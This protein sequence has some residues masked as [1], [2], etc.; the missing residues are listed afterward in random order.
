MESLDV[1]EKQMWIGATA[2][3]PEEMAEALDKTLR[4][5]GYAFDRLGEDIE[6]PPKKEIKIFKIKE[7]SSTI[8]FH[9]NVP[10]C[11][12]YPLCPTLEECLWAYKPL[13][14]VRINPVN[15]DLE[16]ILKRILSAWTERL[17]REI[18]RFNREYL[19][20]YVN[21]KGIS[22]AQLMELNFLRK[23][24]RW[25]ITE[26]PTGVEGLPEGCLKL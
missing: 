10:V 18:W 11:S 20:Y 2:L 4:D 16:P 5:L 12:T 7:P 3:S 6:Y 17:P 9:W 1:L 21:E 23:W 19:E 13:G 8:A 22:R 24:A 15:E 14:V 26:F 25:G